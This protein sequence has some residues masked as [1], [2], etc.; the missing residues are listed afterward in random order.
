MKPQKPA[1]QDGVFAILFAVLLV[2]ILSLAGLALDIGFAYERHGDMKNFANVAALAAAHELDGTVAGI[3]RAL[4]QADARVRAN[5]WGNEYPADWDDA[6]LSLG[7]TPDGPWQD[8]AYVRGLPLQELK[9]YRYARV[10]AGLLDSAMTTV[11]RHFPFGGQRENQMASV[12]SVAGPVMT[13]MLPLAICAMDDDAH[14]GRL[15]WNRLGVEE[16]VEHGFRRGV[17]YNL[18]QLN[19]EGTEPASYVVNP[20]DFPDSG[21]GLDAANFTH[22]AVAPFVCSGTMPQPRTDQVYVQKPF[23]TSL[24]PEINSRLGLS[25]SCAAT[26]ALP[27]RNIKDYFSP[28]PGWLPVNPEQPYAAPRKTKGGRLIS[29]ADVD[30]AEEDDVDENST[31]PFDPD[32][33]DF[34][35]TKAYGTLWAYTRPVRYNSSSATYAGPTFKKADAANLYPDDA[36]I[37]LGDLSVTPYM[38]GSG[39]YFQAPGGNFLRFRRVLHI[40]LLACPVTGNTATIVAVGKFFLTSQA[41]VPVTGDP[42]IAAE[43]AGLVSGAPVSTETRLFQ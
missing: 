16:L 3:D 40:P 6:A 32:N 33:P 28:Y 19:P 4:D 15:V 38:N 23:P 29:V 12:V 35:E 2:V 22:E 26:A 14:K 36:V 8:A 13:Q 18:L 42:Y 10:D 34:P 17:S 9:L 41:K 37:N 39:S 27:D 1:A 24:F 25:S 11:V 43:F 7:T 20:V 31:A 5:S 21:G 30:P